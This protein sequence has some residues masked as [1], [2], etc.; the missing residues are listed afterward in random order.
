MINPQ[1]KLPPLPLGQ[2]QTRQ[3]HLLITV[4]VILAML[5]IAHQM[6]LQPTDRQHS[7]LQ[8]E[9]ATARQQADLVQSLATVTKV[10][11]EERH[12]LPSRASTSTLFQEITTMAAS[13]DVIVNTVTPQS[14]QPISR[15]ARLPIRLEATGT[16]EPVMQFVHD[17]ENSPARFHVDGLELVAQNQGANI[18]SSAEPLTNPQLQVRLT[19]SILLNE[20]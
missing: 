2:L 5:I 15:Y 1:L 18:K 20:S 7:I 6:I 9:L 11:E 12:K 10:L 19:V 17:L 16:F 3:Q 8:Q 14:P 4:T 13:H